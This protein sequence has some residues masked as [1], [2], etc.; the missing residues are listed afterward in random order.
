[1]IR[2]RQDEEKKIEPS[3]GIY[4]NRGIALSLDFFQTL[5]TFGG[6]ETRC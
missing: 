5:V 3:F 6:T 4:M 2:A 1:M